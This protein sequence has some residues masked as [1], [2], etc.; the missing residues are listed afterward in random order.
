MPEATPTG[1]QYAP[2][3]QARKGELGFALTSKLRS[4]MTH[5][6]SSRS[7]LNVYSRDSGNYKVV[8]S[9]RHLTAAIL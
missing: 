2:V 4:Q 5:V 8:R 1:W 6:R 9:T 7:V 3:R